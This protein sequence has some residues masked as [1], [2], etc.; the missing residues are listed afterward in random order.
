MTRESLWVQVQSD[1][2]DTQYR[3]ICSSTNSDLERIRYFADKTWGWYQAYSPEKDFQQK[4]MQDTAS[5]LWHLRLAHVFQGLGF[6]FI[7]TRESQP[8]FCLEKNGKRIWVEAVCCNYPQL[9]GDAISKIQPCDDEPRARISQVFKYKADKYQGFFSDLSGTNDYFIIAISTERLELIYGPPELQHPVE[10][11]L[12]EIRRITE[13]RGP[14]GIVVKRTVEYCNELFK[15]KGVN[16]PFSI[17]DPLTPI[18]IGYFQNGSAGHVSAV[19][20]A[21]MSLFEAQASPSVLWALINNGQ[22]NKVLPMD[23]FGTRAMNIKPMPNVIWI[24]VPDGREG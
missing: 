3:R 9:P 4:L 15:R 24:P 21:G 23:V 7:E 6:N 12:N 20:T 8:D 18:P 14:G 1:K 19:M 10:D 16:K 13:H 17:S 5:T 22:T 2:S 11:V